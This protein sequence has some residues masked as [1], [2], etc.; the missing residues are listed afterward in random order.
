MYKSFYAPIAQLSLE[1]KGMLLD[2]IFIYQIEKTEPEPTSPIYVAFMFFKT[3]FRLDEIKYDKVLEAK[4]IA[5]KQGGI[6]S[7]LSRNEAKKADASFGS[8]NEANEGDND[9]VNETDN[10]KSLNILF[11]V[12][13][14]VYGKKVGDKDKCIKTWEKLKDEERTK[15]IETLP[16]FKAQF[17]DKQYLPYPQKYLSN[18]RWNDVIETKKTNSSLFEKHKDILNNID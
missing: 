3:Q 15:I 11:S 7:G 16:L 10:E 17:T 2:A 8:K 12:F 13:W 1:Y 18:K 5:G 6:N 14:D 4:I 9:N